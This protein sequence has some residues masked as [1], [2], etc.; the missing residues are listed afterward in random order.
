MTL[1]FPSAPSPLSSPPF[2]HSVD[3]FNPSEAERHLDVLNAQKRSRITE[4]VSAGNYAFALTH[5]GVCIAFD[6]GK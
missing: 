6:V 5:A 3:T 1:S 4:I 2:Q